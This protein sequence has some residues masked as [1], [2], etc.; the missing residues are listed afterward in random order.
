LYQIVVFAV[1]IFGIWNIPGARLLINPLKLLTI[2]FHELCHI[3]AAILT[4]G[5]V[6]RVTID[7]ILGGATIVEGGHP[8]TILSAGYFGSTMFGGLF[9]LASWDTLVAKIMS[10]II[11]VGLVLPLALIRDKL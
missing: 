10:F 4:G 11:G 9:V 5:T 1:V 6:L 2:G 3:S 8:P 7:P